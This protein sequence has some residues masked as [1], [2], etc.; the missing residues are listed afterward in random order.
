[1]SSTRPD[2]NNSQLETGLTNVGSTSGVVS[3]GTAASGLP[4]TSAPPAVSGRMRDLWRMVT[5]N[6]KVGIGVLILV[7]FILVAIFGPLF[8]HQDPNT[9]NAG[10]T[11][12]PPSAQFL[13]GTTQTGQNVFTQTIVSTRSSIFWGFLTALLI[14]AFSTSVGLVA[15]YCG[16]TVDDI[17]SIFINVFLVI[18]GLPLAI[19]LAAFF[20]KGDLTVA[21]VLTITSWSWNARV[22]RA[23]TMSMRS[24]DFVQ[25]AQSSG[26][27]TL[28]IIFAEILPNEIAI[29]MSGFIG[30]VVYVILAAAGLQFL[31]LGSVTSLSWGAMLYWVNNNDA[32]LQGAYWWFIP[33]TLCIALV[34]TALSLINFGVDEIANPRLRKEAKPKGSKA[35]KVVA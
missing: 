25:A 7:F 17:L 27:G 4:G 16:G 6:R 20:P 29:V 26:E 24:R 23:Q 2:A 11:L 33:P 19:V 32:I 13:F 9:L 34:G 30:T 35:K 18:P 15:G 12:A 10:P 3:V 8:I 22:I 28:H 1:M 21:F 5:L 14:T 31:G